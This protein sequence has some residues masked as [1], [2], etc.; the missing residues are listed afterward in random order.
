[1]KL[2]K[3]A[4]WTVQD[5]NPNADGEAMTF[6]LLLVQST[7]EAL[8]LPMQKNLERLG[9]EMK[10]R[11]VDTSQYIN[12]IRAFDYDMIVIGLPAIITPGNEQRESWHSA[13]AAEQG[14]WNYAGAEDPVL[15]KLVEMVIAA[16]DYDELVARAKAL[17]RVVMWGHYVIPQLYNDTFR[18]A[19]W[20][21][22]GR[23]DRLPRYATGFPS[24]WWIDPDKDAA[25]TT[26]RKT[27]KN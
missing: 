26:W 23:P 7:L 22:F 16:P 4:G 19:Y 14:S 11:I 18:I 3:E 2:F 9:V 15:D 20:N 27:R 21:R 8:A 5:G 17:D 12:R 25:V 10:L 6:E 13:K 24:T 1:M